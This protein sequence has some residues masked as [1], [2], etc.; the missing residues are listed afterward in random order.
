[1]PPAVFAAVAIV[2][3]AV[4]AYGTIK[5]GQ[6]QKAEAGFEAKQMQVK[7]LQDQATAE[8][9]ALND[10]RQ[11][12]ILG[13]KVQADAAASGGGALDPSV[14]N[15][16]SNIAG[17]GEYRALTA[18]Y[19]GDESAA[20]LTDEANAKMFQGSQTSKAAN[21]SA[22]GTFLQS[23]ASAAAGG[24]AG[25]YGGGGSAPTPTT[26]NFGGWDFPMYKT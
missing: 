9:V 19:Q 13:S 20:G 24:L 7:G 10:K 8:R 6:A 26:D 2:G 11:A 21:I 12:D 4:A 5:A 3:A 18:L 25:K 14:V 23:S 15:I 22:A 16:Q 1:M 17:E